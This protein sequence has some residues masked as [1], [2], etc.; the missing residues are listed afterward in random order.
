MTIKVG[1]PLDLVSLRKKWDN[2]AIDE[3]DLLRNLDTM[4]QRTI[5]TLGKTGRLSKAKVLSV[6]KALRQQEG[7]EV[8]RQSNGILAPCDTASGQGL[9]QF[10][11]SKLF[12]NS[13]PLPRHT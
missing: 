11:A 9:I 4:A 12:K 6:L 1:F 13:A 10:R 7:S 5:K 2:E 3:E 8:A